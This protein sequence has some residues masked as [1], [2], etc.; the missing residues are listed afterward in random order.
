MVLLK[1]TLVGAIF[2]IT[3]SG[4]TSSTDSQKLVLAKVGSEK[5]TEKDFVKALEPKLK[6]TYL[7]FKKQQLDRM[8][9]QKLLDQ[10][11]KKRKIPSQEL[12]NKEV[13][14]QATVSHEEVHVYYE[15]NKG[16]F[17]KK[18]HEEAQ[19]EIQKLLQNE[20]IQT[21]LKKF[22]AGLSSKSKIK[23]FLT[24]EMARQK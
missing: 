22:L 10:E 21:L 5:I 13:L 20:K 4:C 14:S 3:F 23:Y 18:K 19:V 2:L 6:Q 9:A 11:A 15:K 7:Q 24:E 17:K 12:L 16:N 1:N 8:V